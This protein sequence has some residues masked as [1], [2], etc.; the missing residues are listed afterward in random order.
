M[1]LSGNLKKVLPRLKKHAE[2]YP[3]PG[4]LCSVIRQ[5]Q[6]TSNMAG[7]GDGKAS[8]GSEL[9][10]ERPWTK[11]RTCDRYG[12]AAWGGMNTVSGTLDCDAHALPRR[13][14]KVR[15]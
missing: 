6:K 7:V 1:K 12:L 5:G 11:R 15:T 4:Y 14:R 3:E 9:I 10:I 8:P 2:G 13:H